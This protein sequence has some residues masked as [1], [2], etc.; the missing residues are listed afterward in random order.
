MTEG[1]YAEKY[2]EKFGDKEVE[3][4]AA[5][6]LEKAEKEIDEQ[7]EKY[8]KGEANFDEGL[9]EYDD[10]DPKEWNKISEGFNM[11]ASRD[12][13]SYGF[14]YDPNAKNTPEELERLEEIYKD[15]ERV[16]VSK[17]YDSPYQSPVQ[18][19]GAC[20]SCAAFAT[21]GGIE[22][23]FLKAVG[24]PISGLNIGKSTV[25]FINVKPNIIVHVI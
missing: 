4:E 16:D 9:H 23:C 25:Y 12:E 1:E 22:S 19:Q 15:L 18:H 20:G 17:P 7:H 24:S 10:M 5:G 14:I 3:Q 8:E 11:D 6:F 2:H 21:A 13:Y